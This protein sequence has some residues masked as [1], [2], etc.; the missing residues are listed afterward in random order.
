[1]PGSFIN[2]SSGSLSGKS[3]ACCC[4]CLD[5]VFPRTHKWMQQQQQLAEGWGS[6]GEVTP[7]VA[8]R[9]FIT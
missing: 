2:R 8:G 5:N 7:S 3:I 4:S 9:G 1:M 6:L